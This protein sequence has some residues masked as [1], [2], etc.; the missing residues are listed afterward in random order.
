MPAT[1]ARRGEENKMRKNIEALQ[2]SKKGD[3]SDRK[4]FTMCCGGVRMRATVSNKG[5]HSSSHTW[6]FG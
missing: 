6:S 3:T 2:H 1:T 4:N 5:A